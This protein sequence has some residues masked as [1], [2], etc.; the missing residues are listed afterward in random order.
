MATKLAFGPPWN[1][2]SSDAKVAERLSQGTLELPPH[3]AWAVPDQLNWGANPFGEV[4]WVAQF[5]MLR[6][7]DPLRRQA[8]RG[9]TAYMDTWEK[10]ALSWIADNPPGRGKA[11]YAWADMVEAARAVTFCL[12][13]PLLEKRSEKVLQTVLR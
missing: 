10:V 2:L 9:N 6:W 12:A 5:H 13:L 7:L 3:R 8:E 1:R 4:N 11:S